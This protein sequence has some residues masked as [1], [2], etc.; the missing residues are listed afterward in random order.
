MNANTSHLR[1]MRDRAVG[2]VEL[3]SSLL[4]NTSWAR[5][6]TGFSLSPHN[7]RRVVG[8]VSCEAHGGEEGTPRGVVRANGEVGRGGGEGQIGEWAPPS[9]LKVAPTEV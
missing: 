3:F 9:S 7:W 1:M 6:P 5:D 4:M 8:H 2:S